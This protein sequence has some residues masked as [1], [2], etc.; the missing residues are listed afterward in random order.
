MK[1][2]LDIDKL[3]ADGQIT[4]DEY[5]RLKGFSRQETGTLGLNILIGFG[6][7]ATTGGMLA[8]LPSMGTPIALGA[9]IALAGGVLSMRNTQQWGLLGAILLLVG[10]VM[11]SGGLIA[12][13]EGSVAGFLLVT[14]LCAV[15]AVFVRSA[16]LAT[17]ATLSLSATVGAMAT[18]DHASYILLM[19]QPMVT[20][21][22]FAVLALAC[23][24]LSTRL[25]PAYERIALTSARTS[26]ILVNFGFWIGS[27][28]GDNLGGGVH[29]P[30]QAF[31]LVWAIALV[32]TGVWAARADRRWVVNVISVFG[33]FHFYTQ[34]FERLGASPGSVVGAGLV[35]IAIAVALAWY[36]KGASRT[37]ASA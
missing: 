27:L 2:V 23:Y 25:P 10:T 4:A 11:L 18:Y 20:V 8:L 26:L 6:V 14:V 17:L 37:A 30:E 16:L 32:A 24:Q 29:I 22:M 19:R 34:Y 13:T 35:A 12:L 33:S 9:L 1:I 31:A 21:V 36:N 7:I 5:H 28:W 15:A 3:L